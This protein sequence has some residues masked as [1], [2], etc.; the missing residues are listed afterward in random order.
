[1]KKLFPGLFKWMFR[2][3]LIKVN[4]YIFKAQEV[5][6]HREAQKLENKFVLKEDFNE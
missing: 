2:I 6:I 4:T 5:P 1:M 3:Y